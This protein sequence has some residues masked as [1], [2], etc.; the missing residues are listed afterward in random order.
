MPAYDF[1]A[2]TLKY[3]YRVNQM[4]LDYILNPQQHFQK[5]PGVFERQNKHMCPF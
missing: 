4:K 2:I 1:V 5:V 3:S